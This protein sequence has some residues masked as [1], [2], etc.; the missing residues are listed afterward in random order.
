[1]GKEELQIQRQKTKNMDAPRENI[2]ENDHREDFLDARH[3]TVKKDKTEVERDKAL[4]LLKEELKMQSFFNVKLKD[5]NI[6]ESKKDIEKINK[7]I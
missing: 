1:M 2:V 7:K 6:E 3:A 5:K 4:N